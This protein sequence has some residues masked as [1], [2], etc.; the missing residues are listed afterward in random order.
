VTTT[1]HSASAGMS[2]W[3]NVNVQYWRVASLVLAIMIA[4]PIV[5]VF[6]AWLT[7]ADD[8]WQHLARTVL[9]ELVR[10][11]LVLVLG[12]CAGVLLL[13]VGLAWLTAMCEFPGRKIFEW[14]LMLPLAVPAY[15]L[16][17]VLVGLLDFSGPVA[18]WWREVFGRQAGFPEVRSTWGVITVM[19]L[20]FYPYVYML[21]RT[22]FQS[23]GR[24]LLDSGRVL[25]LGPW[26]AFFHVALPMARPAI[27]AGAALAVMEALADFGAVSVFNYDTFT[28][29][30]YKS[31][32]GLFNL[33]AA[34]QLASLLLLFVLVA[35]FS[36]RRLRKRARFDAQ[37]K[38]AHTDRFHL[39]KGHAWMATGV[40]SL[41]L[42]IAFI[43][44][45][46]QLIAAN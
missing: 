33:N 38:D 31:W 27:A 12:V 26:S 28:T 43:I 14:A 22:A 18:S 6:S 15:V 37:H 40:A 45:V 16:A 39:G 24:S 25:G 9:P 11:T 5:V 20:A 1:S 30:I 32:L 36:E 21:A 46:G 44:P 2:A 10:N 41:V 4:I 42:A 8:V 19:V 34:A 23:Q 3:L 7:P 29:A 35:V 17:F 13:G